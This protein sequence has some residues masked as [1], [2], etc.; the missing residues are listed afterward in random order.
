[1]KNISIE[2]MELVSSKRVRRCKWQIKTVIWIVAWTVAVLIALWNLFI[3]PRVLVSHFEEYGHTDRITLSYGVSAVGILCIGI[4][5]IISCLFDLFGGEE[6]YIDNEKLVSIRHA[7][8]FKRT[9]IVRLTDII[10]VT[11]NRGL[12]SEDYFFAQ[13][14][15]Y[16]GLLVNLVIPGK[17]LFWRRRKYCGLNYT[18]AETSS[19]MMKIYEKRG[20]E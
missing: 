18:K 9:K 5:G 7:L 20:Y 11:I 17:I 15:L 1:M 16:N 8:C 19:L 14:V 2:N 6:I 12:T 10:D 4:P 13:N 3:I